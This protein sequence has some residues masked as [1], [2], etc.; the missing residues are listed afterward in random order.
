MPTQHEIGQ[1]LA[2]VRERAGVTQ[3]AAGRHLLKDGPQISKWERGEQRMVAE[4]FL[5]LVVFYKAEQALVN[6]LAAWHR[7]AAERAMGQ[8]L[9]VAE[10]ASSYHVARGSVP[11]ATPLPRAALTKVA[12]PKSHEK[13]RGS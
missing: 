8:L 3:A 10:P 12:G 5:A 13:K 7:A 1:W 6:Q 4:S 9:K 2:E 11:K